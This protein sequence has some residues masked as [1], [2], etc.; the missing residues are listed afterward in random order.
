MQLDAGGFEGSSPNPRQPG[1]Q[2]LP[3]GTN[4]K[5]KPTDPTSGPSNSHTQ[6]EWTHFIAP[7]CFKNKR[8][9]KQDMSNE[10]S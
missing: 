6:F 1:R 5:E 10:V 7:R 8:M 9:E 2:V 4:V 3:G